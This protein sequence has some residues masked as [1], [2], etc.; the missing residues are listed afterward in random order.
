[1]Y[2]L[3]ACIYG[4]GECFESSGEYAVFA[5][6]NRSRI[7]PQPGECPELGPPTQL[8]APMTSDPLTRREAQRAGRCAPGGQVEDG[9]HQVRS[10]RGTSIKQCAIGAD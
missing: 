2:L 1:M 7:A 3:V 4:S 8:P 10:M 5:K 6:P 9:L